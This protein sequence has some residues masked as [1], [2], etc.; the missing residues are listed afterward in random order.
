MNENQNQ[1]VLFT[2]QLNVDQINVVLSQV[3]KLP[4][5]TISGLMDTMRAQVNIQIQ[6][7]Q[8]QQASA[9]SAGAPLAKTSD[10]VQ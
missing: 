5:E 3:G 9:Q 6:Q 7:I 1:P 2:L 8:E 4:Y 10:T